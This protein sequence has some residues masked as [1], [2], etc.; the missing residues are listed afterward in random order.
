M[1]WLYTM[2]EEC[3]F[4][5]RMKGGLEYVREKAGGRMWCVETGN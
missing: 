5:G 3:I 4:L 1:V 2:K